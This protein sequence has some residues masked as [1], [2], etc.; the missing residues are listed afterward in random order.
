MRKML[1]ALIALTLAAC[2]GQSYPSSTLPV[3]SSAQTRR[4]S[5]REHHR[6]PATISNVYVLEPNEILRFPAGED[7]STPDET[8]SLSYTAGIGVPV[9][10][11]PVYG[12]ALAVSP[13][14]GNVA[15]IHAGAD[16]VSV[17][18]SNLGAALY[19]ITMPN[20][21]HDYAISIAVTYDRYGTPSVATQNVPAMAG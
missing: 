8:K 18:G 15:V 10:Y 12:N 5:P 2:S 19:T 9:G 14:N 20:S 13:A 17:Y 7:T 6:E 11:G 16:K 3:A 21:G 4:E 1:L